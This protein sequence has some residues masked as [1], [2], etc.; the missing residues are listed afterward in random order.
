MNLTAEN[1]HEVFMKCLFKDAEPQD[2][3]VEGCGVMMRM[4]FHPGRLEEN[5]EKIL[6]MLDGLPD[7]FKEG[8]GGGWS[9][10]NACNDKNGNQWADMHQTMDELVCLGLALK[11][12]KFQLPREM[13]GAFPGGMPYFS[14]SI[15][16]TEG[17]S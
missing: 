8:K 3:P 1:V 16:E 17:V 12:L 11:V 10:L 2:N 13:W 14:V 5:R 7:N 6:S 4:G 9:F 15:P